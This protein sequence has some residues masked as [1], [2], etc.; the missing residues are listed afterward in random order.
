MY[1]KRRGPD[2][3]EAIIGDVQGG[4]SPAI[5]RSIS[6]L[7]PSRDSTQASAFEGGDRKK[8][9][10]IRLRL[11]RVSYL[12][13]PNIGEIVVVKSENGCEDSSLAR[14]LT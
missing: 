5:L 13:K 3:Q 8:G 7:E 11:Y 1:F 4:T 9:N 14:D 12:K 6:R 2:V 10:K